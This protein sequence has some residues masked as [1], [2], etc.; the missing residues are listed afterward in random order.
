MKVILKNKTAHQ[1]VRFLMAAGFSACFTIGLP[2]L[3]HDVMGV[4]E[5]V[6]VACSFTAAFVVNFVTTR[7]FVFK[8]KGDH[9]KELTLYIAANLCFRGLEFGMFVV[10]NEMTGLFKPVLLIVLGISMVLKFIVYKFFIFKPLANEPE[11]F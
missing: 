9:R 7:F 6:A 10:L 5:K 4:E 11:A 8:S 3:L 2:I 1:I